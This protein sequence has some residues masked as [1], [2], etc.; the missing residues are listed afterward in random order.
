[1]PQIGIIGGTAF[2]DWK[3]FKVKEERREETPWGTPS[4]PLIIGD[5]NGTEVVL[6]LRHGKNHNIPPHKINNRANIYALERKVDQIVGLSSAGAAK[7]EIEVP[8]ISVPKDYVNFW[9]VTTFY[10]EKIKHATPELSEELREMIIEASEKAG[11]DDVR[12]D[13]VYVQTTGPRLETRAEVNILKNFGELI[14]MTMA[15]EA[16]LCKEVGLEYASIVTN[17]NYAHGVNDVKVDYEEIK[18]TA[19]EN[20]SNVEKI[21]KEFLEMI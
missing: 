7:E 2:K 16:T 4:S 6:L 14:G 5:V 21:L 18:N 11:F 12:T 13:D 15:P 3:S 1:M 20:W 10:N 8:S 9:N 17:D 19:R